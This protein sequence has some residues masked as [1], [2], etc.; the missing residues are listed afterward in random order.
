MISAMN[1]SL[2]GLQVTAVRVNSTANNVANLNTDGFKKSRVVQSAEE[3]QGVR[4]TVERVETP[5]PVVQEQTSDKMEYV[6]KSNVDLA[7][8]MPSMM[9]SQHTYN[10]NIKTMQ[11]ADEMAAT[12]LDIK[13]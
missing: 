13:G 10:A 11:T 9:M 8:E 5:G 12:L 1:A 3:L 7:E 6:E 4:A 2:S